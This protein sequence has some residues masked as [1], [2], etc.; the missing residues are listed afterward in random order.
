MSRNIS[1][2]LMTLTFCI[3]VGT[4]AKDSII[5]NEIHNAVDDKHDWIEIKNITN[6]EITLNS[7]EISIVTSSQDDED[8][9]SFTGLD[10][11]LKPGKLILITNALHTDTDLIQGQN[12]V[13]PPHNPVLLPSYL[14]APDLRLPIAPYLLIL[15]NQPDLNGTPDQIED[16][17][18]NYYREVVEDN[19]DIWPLHDTKVF[20]ENTQFLTQGKAWQRTEPIRDGYDPRA[21]EESGYKSGLGYDMNA[22]KA[23]SLGTPGYSS[24]IYLRNVSSGEVVFSEIMFATNKLSWVEPQWIELYNASNTKVV[25]LEGW[26]LIFETDDREDE[27]RNQFTSINLKSMEILPKQTVL[28]VSDKSQHSDN[29]LDRQIYD[30]SEHHGTELGLNTYPSFIFDSK[31]FSLE[32]KSPDNTSVDKVGNMYGEVGNYDLLF[33]FLYGHRNRDKARVSWIRRF[34]E[35]GTVSTGD[36]LKSWKRTAKLQ[37]FR[38]ADVKSYYGKQTDLGTPG[39]RSTT[40]LPDSL[41]LPLPVSLSDFSAEVMD[42]GVVIKWTTE[43]ELNNAGFNIYRS[44]TKEGEFAA[45]NATL[46]KGAG[47]TGERNDYTWI[48]TSAKPNIAYYYQIE[49]VSFT[50]EGQTHTTARLKGFI[51]AKNKLATTWSTLKRLPQSK[52]NRVLNVF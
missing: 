10:Y 12:I 49:D 33:E 20:F 32:L 9:V 27:T 50:G 31:G 45:V 34:N 11:K 16:V 36:E 47:T 22:D 19:T 42:T 29:I 52:K 46:I 44:E 15:R 3:S 21:W 37:S 25:D 41:S 13:D 1:V 30:L 14:V 40:P 5:F 24:D 18:G 2:F 43:S 17:A 7:W 28:L 38:F 39:Y 6:R 48:D 8:I 4:A 23:T 51:S 26:L 35:D